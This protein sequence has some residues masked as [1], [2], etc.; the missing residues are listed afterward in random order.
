MSHYSEEEQ[1]E[2]EA[3]FSNEEEGKIRTRLIALQEKIKEANVPVIVVLCGVNGSGKNAALSTFRDWMDQRLLVLKAYEQRNVQQERVE[4]RRYWRDTPSK[5]KT[6]VFVSSWY[7]D[8]LV[9]RAYGKTDDDQLY[10]RLDECNTFEKMLADSGVIF[11]KIWFHKKRGEQETFLKALDDDPYEKWRVMDEDWKNFALSDGFEETTKKIIKYTNKDNAPW[12]EISEGTFTD[13]IRETMTLFCSHVE[14][15]L[16]E[17]EKRKEK[18]SKEEKSENK[19]K[20]EEKPYKPKFLKEIDIDANISKEEYREQLPY[21][22][23]RLNALLMEVKKRNKRVILAFEGPDASG[24]GGAISRL[25]SSVY[26]RDCDIFPI[27]APTDDEN[28][29]HYLWRFWRRLSEQKLLT[30]FDRSWYGR[31]L[32]ERIEHFATDEEWKRA[33]AEINHFEKQLT[34][35]DNYVLKFLMYISKDEQ[36]ARFKAREETS[37]KKWK[38]GSE[39]WRNREKWNEY[40]EAFDE[41]LEKT[42]TKYAPWHVIPDNNKKF[43]RIKTMQILCD[44]LEKE[45]D[46]DPKNDVPPPEKQDKER[47]DKKDKAK[48]KKK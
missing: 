43:G 28:K 8:P 4:Y 2:F 7:S 1:I 20:K 45:L 6:G 10:E 19:K 18:E 5:G 36:L 46:Y 30:V 35:G 29:R 22:R 9:S 12:Y 25:S 47:K 48:D 37:Y 31:V 39:D 41:M 13:R 23:A 27:S 16:D 40:D 24:K 11:C 17:H 34:Q 14:K 44:Y 15:L 26:V 3:S 21:L 38:I 42:D 33:Y 32:V